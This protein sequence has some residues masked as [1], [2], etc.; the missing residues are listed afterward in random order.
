MSA[1]KTD[2]S[3]ATDNLDALATRIDA[4]HSACAAALKA[5][6]AHALEAGRL[7][8]EAKAAVGHGGWSAWLAAH[9]AVSERTAQ[10]YMRVAKHAAELGAGDPRRVADL[11]LRGALAMLAGPKAEPEPE[12]PTFAGTD[13][14]MTAED[15]ARLAELHAIV[16][17]QAEDILE[18]GRSCVEL[19]GML[20]PERYAEWLEAEHHDWKRD[21]I[22]MARI[23][24]SGVREPKRVAAMMWGS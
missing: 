19:E 13:V 16:D 18:T 15:V 21:L 23:Y 14:P 1:I 24:R 12:A 2:S 3:A 7:L 6:L 5:G 17:G 11:S 22:Q 20:G 10:G 8:L 4:E 9:C